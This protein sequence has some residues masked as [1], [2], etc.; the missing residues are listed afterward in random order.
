MVGAVV[1][2]DGEIVGRG[3]H[4]WA[5]VKHAEIDGAR[6]GRRAGPRR[7]PL[8]HAR[9]VLAYRAARRPCADALIAAG[10]ARVVA[11]MQDP[12]PLVGG[13]GFEKLR[14]AGIEVEIDI[15]RHGGRREA[16]RAVRP[17]HA[18]RAVRWSR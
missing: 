14:E 11:A 16:E 10:V 13:R 15:G 9:T 8:R 5:G 3:F 4:T 1:V 12:N 18:N 2:R 6:R 7:H 17:L